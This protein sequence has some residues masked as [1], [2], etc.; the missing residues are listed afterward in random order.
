MTGHLR[1]LLTPQSGCVPCVPSL[2]CAWQVIPYSH[3]KHHWGLT[4]PYC[5]TMV[6]TDPKSSKKSTFSNLKTSFRAL[7]LFRQ[8]SSNGEAFIELGQRLI[9]TDFG[10]K[11]KAPSSEHESGGKW[12]HADIQGSKLLTVAQTL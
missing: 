4:Q 11:R 1:S 6:R 3:S 10:P 7:L 8:S 2:V 5:S 12:V 9:I